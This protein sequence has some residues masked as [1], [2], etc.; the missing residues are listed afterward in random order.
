VGRAAVQKHT[1]D[2]DRSNDV[3]PILTVR[4]KPFAVQSSRERSFDTQAIEI[5]SS[6]DLLRTWMGE[7]PSLG[8][9]R[10]TQ[11]CNRQRI[12]VWCTTDLMMW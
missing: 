6:W 8:P 3:S 11:T 4:Q 2:R 1:D 5:V 9:A 7:R 12:L 10:M